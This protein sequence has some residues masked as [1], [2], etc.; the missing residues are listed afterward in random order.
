MDR[1]K[2]HQQTN[3][4]AKKERRKAVKKARQW[5][6]T[7]ESIAS[8]KKNWNEPLHRMVKQK[9]RKRVSEMKRKVKRRREKDTY[10]LW[11]NTPE[12]GGQEGERVERGTTII[13]KK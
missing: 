4:G 13:K 6:L 10:F 5:I 3:E 12:S 7:D 9:D 8:L 2:E 1:K 11:N